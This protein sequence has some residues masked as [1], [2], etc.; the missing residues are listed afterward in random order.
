M[1]AQVVS[2]K[3]MRIKATFHLVAL[4]HFRPGLG[5]LKR[6]QALESSSIDTAISNPQMRFP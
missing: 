2:V 1:I 6:P 3:I 4:T 5:I